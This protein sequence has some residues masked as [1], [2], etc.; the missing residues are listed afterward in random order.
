MQRHTCSPFKVWL[1]ETRHCT[2]NF[3]LKLTHKLSLDNPSINFHS[4]NALREGAW[5]QIGY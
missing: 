3:D 1:L 4:V 2:K 5:L